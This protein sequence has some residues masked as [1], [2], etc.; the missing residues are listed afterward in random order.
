MSDEQL[1]VVFQNRAV[2]FSMVS[3]SDEFRIVDLLMKRGEIV[4]VTG[5]GVNDTLRL[6]RSDIGIAMGGKHDDKPA[7]KSERKNYHQ[8]DHERHCLLRDNHGTCCLWCIFIFI[9]PH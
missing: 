3:P 4:A 6:T 2:I 7:T 1:K 9:Q 8:G 5:D